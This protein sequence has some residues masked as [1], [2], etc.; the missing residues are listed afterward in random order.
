MIPASA[1]NTAARPS[2]RI[3]E[4]SPRDGLQALNPRRPVPIELKVKLIRALAQSGVAYIEVGAFVSPRAVPQMADSSEVARAVADLKGVQRAALVPNLIYY[5]AFAASGCDTLALFVSASESYSQ[6]NLRMSITEAFTAA[7]AVA[8][9]ARADGFRMRAHL[10]AAFESEPGKPSDVAA[11]VKLCQRLRAMGCEE[12]SLADTYGTASPARVRDVTGQVATAIGMDHVALHLH[13]TL[14]LGI[15]SA[16]AAR[17]IGVSKFDSSVGGIGGSPFST[18]ASGNI[19]TEEL[20]CLLDSMGAVTGVDLAALARAGQIVRQITQHT[21][22]PD[23]PSRA[24]TYLERRFLTPLAAPGQN[25][26]L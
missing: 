20:V 24:L 1:G 4:M 2:V 11:V 16:M 18:T 3:C 22:D 23:P 15:A 5:D 21:G 6:S 12:V 7:Q 25:T 17:Q 13:D 10:S 8:E 14:G 9:R 26:G 19:A